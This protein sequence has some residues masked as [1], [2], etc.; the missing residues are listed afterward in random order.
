MS[1]SQGD[2]NCLLELLELDDFKMKEEQKKVRQ[3]LEDLWRDFDEN[4]IDCG[5]YE[6]DEDLPEEPA[7]SPTFTKKNVRRKSK[8]NAEQEIFCSFCKNNGRSSVFYKSHTKTTCE[9]LKKYK[10]PICAK[11]GHT[12][13]YCPQK[14]IVE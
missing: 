10:C 6:E 3:K 11:K 13:R 14:P 4:G 5:P 1:I 8:G 2:I 12:R 9:V 7:S